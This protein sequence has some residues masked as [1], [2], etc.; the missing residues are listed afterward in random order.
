MEIVEYADKIQLVSE[1]L[2]RK[3]AVQKLTKH[4]HSPGFLTRANLK[5]NKK[6]TKSTRH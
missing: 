5:L 6:P 2:T 1:E 3:L 4:K